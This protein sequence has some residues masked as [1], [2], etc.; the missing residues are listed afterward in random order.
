VSQCGAAWIWRWRCTVG[1]KAARLTADPALSER[2]V[3]EL[4]ESERV[5]AIAGPLTGTAAQAAATQAQK[6]CVPLLTLSQKEGLPE[7]GDY[8]FRSHQPPQVLAL[9]HYPWRSG[10]GRPSLFSARKTGWGER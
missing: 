10:G 9:V 5:L 4:V 6:M 3:I 7:A 2:A 1:G 8:V